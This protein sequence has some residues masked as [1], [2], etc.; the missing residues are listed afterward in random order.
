LAKWVAHETAKAF[1]KNESHGL[2][3]RA[4]YGDQ[5]VI[6]ESVRERIMTLEHHATVSA[7]PGMSRMYYAMRRRYYWP[8]MVTDI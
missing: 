4:P 2:Y 6:P 3:R 5:L 8:S 1:F 7:H